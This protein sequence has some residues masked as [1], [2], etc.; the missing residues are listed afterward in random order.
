MKLLPNSPLMVMLLHSWHLDHSS[1]QGTAVERRLL[2][3]VVAA[4]V[5]HGRDLACSAMSSEKTV[6]SLMAFHGDVLSDTRAS[7]GCGRSEVG[8]ANLRILS[9]AI[10]E[11]ADRNSFNILELSQHSEQDEAWA[12]AGPSRSNT[13][14]MRMSSTISAIGKP[15]LTSD[16]RRPGTIK[17]VR[18][19]QLPEQP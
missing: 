12:T 1:S 4:P 14:L 2:A 8:S 15:R 9:R 11:R 13:S 10:Q 5:P 19:K 16:Q 17:P 18:H 7:R 3:E 6:A